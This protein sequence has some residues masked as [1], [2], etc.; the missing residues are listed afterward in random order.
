MSVRRL[1]FLLPALAGAFQLGGAARPLRHAA[2]DVA[3]P[4]LRHAALRLSE[5]GKKD[6]DKADEEG[7]ALAAA[8]NARLE[9]EGGATQFK[10]KSTLNDAKDSISGAAGS[11]KDSAS[12]IPTVDVANASP[13]TLL[14][15][16]FGVVVLF[17][18][19]S[20]GLNSGPA[21]MNTSDGT[22]LE[23]GKRSENR[24]VVVNPYKADYGRQ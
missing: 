3:Q 18:L 20:A 15:G 7:D 2:V 11:I 24:E 1:C 14:G 16:L 9:Q 5:D 13:T 21:D 22:T 19:V 4:P 8:F 17:T 10:I 6:L 12:N 23:F